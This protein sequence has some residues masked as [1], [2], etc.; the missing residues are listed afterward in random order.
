MAQQVRVLKG[1]T[2]HQNVN[3]GPREPLVPLVKPLV[4]LA[5]SISWLI[6]A[7]GHGT[8]RSIGKGASM[9]KGGKHTLKFIEGNTTKRRNNQESGK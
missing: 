8:A 7:D 3:K 9:A 4:S 5:E 2:N 6:Y 1:L